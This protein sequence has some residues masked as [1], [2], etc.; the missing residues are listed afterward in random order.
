MDVCQYMLT[1]GGGLMVE[2]QGGQCLVISSVDVGDEVR[3]C[4]AVW[5][6][7][8]GG[9]TG[10]ERG[11]LNYKSKAGDAF[12]FAYVWTDSRIGRTAT[13]LEE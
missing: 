12:T 9:R 8:S 7:F 3:S 10:T 2:P 5:E 6:L 13:V 1:M 11:R 4:T